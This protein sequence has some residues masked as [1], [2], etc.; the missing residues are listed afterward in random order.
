VRFAIQHAVVLQD[1]RLTYGLGEVTLAGS[2][3]DKNIMP[4]VPGSSRF[5]TPF[6]HYTVRAFASNGG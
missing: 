5:I 3:R 6:I 2:A 1:R 4:M